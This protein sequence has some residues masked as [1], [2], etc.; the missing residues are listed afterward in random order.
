M[1]VRGSRP[2]RDRDGRARRSPMSRAGSQDPGRRSRRAP[3]RGRPALPLAAG[4][5]AGP[6]VRSPRAHG[7][8]RAP[9]GRQPDPPLVA[10]P[11]RGAEQRP[12]E[13][14]EPAVGE[15]AQAPEQT[16]APVGRRELPGRSGP[17]LE[18]FEQVHID[19]V[20]R[21]PWRP[22]ACARRRAR[23]AREARAGASIGSPAPAG[24]GSARR[25]SARATASIRGAADRR[26]APDRRWASAR[27][28]HSTSPVPG[29]PRAPAAVRTRPARPRRPRGRARDGGTA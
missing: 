13:R 14:D 22:S 21:P 7:C 26:P 3:R 12:V 9:L 18:L 25:P 16:R 5:A 6:A 27:R 11:A 15:A 2:R 8:D 28:R 4:R 1:V 24:R 29:S 19:G 17:R 23:A 20:Q 10:R